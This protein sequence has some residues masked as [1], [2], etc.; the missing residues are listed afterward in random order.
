MLTLCIATASAQSP[1]SAELLLY[2]A[3]FETDAAEASLDPSELPPV[4][5][6]SETSADCTAESTE[7]DADGR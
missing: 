2:L 1:P 7:E 5:D 4:L 3:E 6:C